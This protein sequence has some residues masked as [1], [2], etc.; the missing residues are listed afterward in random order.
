MPSNPLDRLLTRLDQ[1]KSR[2]GPGDAVHVEDLLETISRRRFRDVDSLL[3]F[4]EILLL[5]AP[6]TLTMLASGI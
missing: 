6:L 5:S 1:A 4:H 3:R 2:F